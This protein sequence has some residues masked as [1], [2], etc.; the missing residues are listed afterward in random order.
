MRARL[1]AEYNVQ[2]R[3]EPLPYSA[4]RW[5]DGPP[6][7]ISALGNGRGRMRTEDRNAH[8]VILFT[9]AWDLRYAEENSPDVHFIDISAGD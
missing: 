9:T 3:I 6:L 1:E 5:V 7:E 2:T 4:A 8:P